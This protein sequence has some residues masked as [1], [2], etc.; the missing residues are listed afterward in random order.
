MIVKIIG[1]KTIILMNALSLHRVSIISYNRGNLVLQSNSVYT[2]YPGLHILSLTMRGISKNHFGV[3]F[4][5]WVCLLRL[6]YENKR[7]DKKLVSIWVLLLLILEL[8]KYTST[9]AF[10][11]YFDVMHFYN[12]IVYCYFPL[13]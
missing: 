6:T 12:N 7:W 10:K 11:I 5:C 2:T 13:F 3:L 4:L 9:C 8:F 1:C